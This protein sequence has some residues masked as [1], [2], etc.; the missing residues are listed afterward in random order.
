MFMAIAIGAISVG[1]VLM[2][3]YLVIANVKTSLVPGGMITE[4]NPC[5]LHGLH[6]GANV[7]GNWCANSTS[8]CYLNPQINTSATCTL[9]QHDVNVSLASTQTIIFAG[10]G[11]LAVGIIV[12]A[13]FGLINIFQ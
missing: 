11:L 2:V 4:T 6:E 12:M 1:I 13:A 10:F 7:S 3:A 5:Y 9:L 8:P